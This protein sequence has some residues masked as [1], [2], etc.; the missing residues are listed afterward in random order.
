MNRPYSILVLVFL[1]QSCANHGQLK[2]IEKLPQKLK[3]N[4]GIVSYVDS[5]AWFIED[6]GNSDDIYKT[7]FKGNIIHQLDVKKEK[8]NDWED[9]SKD[10]DGNLYI[11][12]FGNNQNDRK[13][14]VIYKAP[15]PEIEKGKKIPAKKIRFSY[16][17]QQEFPPR[18]GELF[19]DAEAFFHSNGYLY[20]FTKNRANPFTGETF[21]YRV[22]DKKGTY[23]AELVDKIPLCTDWNICQ[24]TSADIS[25]DGKKIVLLSYGKLWII[26]NFSMDELA[27]GDIKEID[28]GIRTQL[29]SVCFSDNQNLLLSDEQRNGTGGNL[30]SYTLN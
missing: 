30:Y 24:V 26:T 6:N 1:L 11:G 28:L 25:P 4:S 8:N 22:P 2:L 20:I 5:T 10:K 9:L 29:E 15:N 19:Y 3:E 27:K 21:V 14:L 12:D 17:E 13:N 7:D 16:P 23:E 18:R